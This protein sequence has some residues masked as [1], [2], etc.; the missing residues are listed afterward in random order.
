MSEEERV[1]GGTV[2]GRYIKGKECLRGA[3]LRGGISKEEGCVRGTL[4]GGQI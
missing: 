3:V 1:F 4:G 2:W